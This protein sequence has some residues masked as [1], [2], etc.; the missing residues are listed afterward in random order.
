VAAT[1]SCLLPDS[2]DAMTWTIGDHGFVMTL[3]SGVPGL[4]AALRHR[5]S[6]EG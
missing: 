2:G 1:G 3:S 6:K 4:I 5:R